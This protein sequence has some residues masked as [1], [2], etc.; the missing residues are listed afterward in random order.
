M[1]SY[2]DSPFKLMLTPFI[3]DPIK[4]DKVAKFL[5]AIALIIMSMGTDITKSPD[6][7]AIGKELTPNWTDIVSSPNLATLI[8][9]TKTIIPKLLS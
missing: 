2:L 8:T 6:I 7:M 1:D 3:K 9:K 4:R 5:K